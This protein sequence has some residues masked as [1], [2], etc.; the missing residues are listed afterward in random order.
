M[1]PL[2]AAGGDEHPETP[3][4]GLVRGM[5]IGTF[6]ALA[7]RL[8]LTHRREAGFPDGFTVI[9]S[10]DQ[11]RMIKRLAK[12]LG[13]DDSRWPARK[14][15]WAINSWKEEGLRPDNIEPGRDA[16][17][18]D[19]LELYGAYQSACERGA[20]VDFAELL[21]RAHE[22]WLKNPELLAHYRNPLPQCSGRRI[23]GLQFD[24]VRLDSR[25]CRRS[26]PGNR[27]GR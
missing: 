7:R 3:A 14:C 9:D 2:L 5:W 26:G 24:S 27:G 6:H 11:L 15:Q 23:P 17:S 13:I 25:P 4:D 22:L 8:L 12:D 19:L 20:M 16:R 1:Q 10:D 21:L 18:R